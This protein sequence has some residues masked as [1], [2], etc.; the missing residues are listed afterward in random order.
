[1]GDIIS[2]VSWEDITLDEVLDW[3][4]Y[5]MRERTYWETNP[6]NSIFK[7]SNY[8][9]TGDWDPIAWQVE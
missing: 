7:G 8:E 1:M 6:E 2:V 4:D 9:L 3:A 5:F